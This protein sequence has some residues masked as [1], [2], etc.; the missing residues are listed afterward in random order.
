MH[1]LP[2]RIPYPFAG[3]VYVRGI[4]L[5]GPVLLLSAP[6]GNHVPRIVL[7]NKGQDLAAGP[8]NPSPSGSSSFFRPGSGQQATMLHAQYDLLEL[9]HLKHS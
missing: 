9:A 4:P 8:G 1:W 3:P 5:Q 7:G 2:T 6:Q